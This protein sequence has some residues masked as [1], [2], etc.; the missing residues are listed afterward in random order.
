MQLLTEMELYIFKDRLN[1]TDEEFKEFVD[2]FNTDNIP[3][4]FDEPAASIEGTTALFKEENLNDV[5][6]AAAGIVDDITDMVEDKS[7][8]I[9]NMVSNPIPDDLLPTTEVIE[10]IKETVVEQAEVVKETV[11]ASVV[12]SSFLGY[13]YFIYFL[14][15]AIVGK[16]I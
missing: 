8:Q 16:R 7:Q 13:E 4:I 5:L 9:A 3:S 2:S 10:E 11:T 12:S 14:I 15:F 6:D 1:M